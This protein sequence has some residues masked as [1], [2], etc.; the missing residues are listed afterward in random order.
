M[1]ELRKRVGQSVS[2]SSSS[3]EQS[4]PSG[5]GQSVQPFVLR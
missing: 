1:A 3:V 4:G 2:S 5:V